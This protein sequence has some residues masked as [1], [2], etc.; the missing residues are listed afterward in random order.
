MQGGQL[1]LDPAAT[2]AYEISCPVVSGNTKG[3]TTSLDEFMERLIA[4]GDPITPQAEKD[5]F[6]STMSSMLLALDRPQLSPQQM[7]RARQLAGLF[8]QQLAK[9]NFPR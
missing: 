2:V 9:A 4:F 6:S 8:L 3:M 1:G 5:S 7:E